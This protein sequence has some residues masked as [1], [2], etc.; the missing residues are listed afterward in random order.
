M[1]EMGK[2]PSRRTTGNVDGEIRRRLHDSAQPYYVSLSS[3]LRSEIVQGRWPPGTQLPTI[4]QLSE[5]YGVAKVTVRQALGTLAAAGLIERI[6][7]KGTFVADAINKPKLIQ[8]DSSWKSLLHMLEGGVPKLL[9]MKPACDLPPQGA[10]AGTALGS[11]RYMRRVHYCDSNPYC[12]LEV[13][14]ANDCYVRAANDFDTKM[15]I[16]VLQRV[17]KRSLGRMTQSFRI[18]TADLEIARL[19][20]LPLNAPIGEVRRVITNRD[21]E[22]LYLGV[23]RYRGDAVVFN[24][25]IEVPPAA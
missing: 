16:P 6:Q 4:D 24:T 14:L 12:M 2:D 9:E 21:G 10:G 7:G 8:L 25:T 1:D 18:L 15:I 20:D 11:Y 22:I 17:A 3:Q 13:F 23:G 19:L 5:R